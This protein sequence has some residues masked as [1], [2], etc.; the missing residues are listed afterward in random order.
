MTVEKKRSPLL[1]VILGIVGLTIFVCCICPMLFSAGQQAGIFPTNEPTSATA[2]T[3]SSPQPVE[4]V[5]DAASP[6][7]T[8]APVL[9]PAGD[10]RDNPVS[11]GTEA[12]IDANMTITIVN[13]LRPADT[14]VS[15]G[16]M[17]NSKPESDQEY[18]KV[19]IQVVCN[20]P[21]SDKCYF[22][23][24]QIKAV[25]A[26]GNI[27]DGEVLLAGVDGVIE[28]GEFFGGGVRKGSMFFIVPK[29]DT[30]VVLFSDPLLFGDTVYLA[31]P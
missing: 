2:A 4:T 8:D 18:V 17:F 3:I 12:Q 7:P 16:N 13:A 28:S 1:P 24:T 5:P 11:A 30:S 15:D 20:K 31:L 14:I 26:D 6:E 19:D 21:S 23:A 9:A 27:V 25:G 22:A 29:G 10:S